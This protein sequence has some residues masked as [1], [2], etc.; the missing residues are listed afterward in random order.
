MDYIPRI[1]KD[2][3]IEEIDKEIHQMHWDRYAYGR[4]IDWPRMWDLLETK[5]LL[6]KQK[7]A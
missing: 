7:G 2:M 5:K 3:T 4:S 6:K 1:Q